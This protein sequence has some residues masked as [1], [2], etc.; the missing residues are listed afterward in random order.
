MESLKS[1]GWGYVGD[2][3]HFI[4][5]WDGISLK[6]THHSGFYQVRNMTNH[7]P[8][9]DDKFTVIGRATAKQPHLTRQRK[10]NLTRE[11]CWAF[12]AELVAQGYTRIEVKRQTAGF[13]RGNVEAW[14]K[15]R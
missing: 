7:L 9:P 1:L 12:H 8:N 14:L 3:T 15:Q 10:S 5:G 11:E 2:T 4:L 13:R 6:N